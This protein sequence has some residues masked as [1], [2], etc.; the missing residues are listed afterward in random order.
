MHHHLQLSQGRDDEEDDDD[1]DDD[2]DE[3]D[4]DVEVDEVDWYRKY[5]HVIQF[6]KASWDNTRECILNIHD[7]DDPLD[8]T[9]QIPVQ[10]KGRQ[11]DKVIKLG[12]SLT[13]VTNKLWTIL[14]F[15]PNITFLIINGIKEGLNNEQVAKILELCP[16]LETFMEYSGGRFIRVALRYSQQFAVT[17]LKGV[18]ERKVT[19]PEE[20]YRQVDKEVA[21]VFTTHS[22]QLR[23]LRFGWDIK[24]KSVGELGDVLN[25]LLTSGNLR[26]L[27]RVQVDIYDCE[28]E[29]FRGRDLSQAYSLAATKG[30]L[31]E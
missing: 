9:D 21:M 14:R 25:V 29:G 11:L 28:D 2:E 17:H 30:I 24:Q 10:F 23:H 22:L 1:D 31:L 19:L 18:W 5:P 27:K 15:F 8:D 26:G 20:W 13:R 7:F 4:S 16:H 12:L 6:R 3:V